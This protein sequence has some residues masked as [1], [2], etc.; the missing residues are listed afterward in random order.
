[1]QP[2]AEP[3]KVHRF[4][5]VFESDDDD[6][7]IVAMVE[8]AGVFYIIHRYV[9]EPYQ[10]PKRARELLKLPL[11]YDDGHVITTNIFRQG[12]KEAALWVY[13]QSF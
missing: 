2:K 12:S 6:Y 3:V 13:R 9:K 4:Q 7:I 8:Q 5:S 11:N 1:M 10:N